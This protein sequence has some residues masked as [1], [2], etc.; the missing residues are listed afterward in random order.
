MAHDEQFLL[1]AA[2]ITLAFKP[3]PQQQ[4]QQQQQQQATSIS[5][6]L[7]VNHCI[8]FLVLVAMSVLFCIMPIR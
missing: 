6:Y 8:N 2:L 3:Q 1:S 7:G 5:V 4:Q